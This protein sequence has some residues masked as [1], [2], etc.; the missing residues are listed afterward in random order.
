MR[1]A[2]HRSFEEQVAELDAERRL[3]AVEACDLHLQDLYKAHGKPRQM[4]QPPSYGRTGPCLPGAKFVDGHSVIAS[5]CG[6]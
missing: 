5:I 2:D 1:K 3:A 4:V 6:Y